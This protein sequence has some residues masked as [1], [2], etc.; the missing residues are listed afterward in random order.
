LLEVY[1]F[2]FNSNIYGRRISVELIEFIRDETKYD[3]VE[4]MRKEIERDVEKAITILQS[5]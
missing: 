2:G 4:E 5:E 3:N 1:L